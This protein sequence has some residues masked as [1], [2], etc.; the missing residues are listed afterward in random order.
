VGRSPDAVDVVDESSQRM[1]VQRGVGRRD[2]DV[3][4]INIL[5]HE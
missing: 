5:G 1:S 4:G 2:D 3:V